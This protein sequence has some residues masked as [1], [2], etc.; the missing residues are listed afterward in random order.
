MNNSGW[1]SG[2]KLEF[3]PGNPGS[4][5]A[6]VKPQKR[7]KPPSVPL[8]NA[9]RKAYLKMFKKIQMIPSS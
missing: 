5:P 9:R 2:K 6:W 4:T 1:S 3:Y 7:P 8:M